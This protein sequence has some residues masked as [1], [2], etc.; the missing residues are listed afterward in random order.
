MSGENISARLS[1]LYKYTIRE[2][3]C[4]QV[5]PADC[6]R[7]RPCWPHPASGERRAGSHLTV[8]DDDLLALDTVQVC[9]TP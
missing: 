8:G 6:Q 9:S 1:F 3:A 2:L 4:A 7:N 5:D